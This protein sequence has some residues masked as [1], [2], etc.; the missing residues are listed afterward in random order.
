MFHRDLA[1]PCHTEGRYSMCCMFYRSMFT[2]LDSLQSGNNP[3]KCFTETWLTHAI[4]RGDIAR[5]L[6]PVLLL[7]LHPDTARI[8]IQH[9]NIHQ[10][11]N[12]KL[13]I[14]SS[15]EEMVVT[16][17]RIYAISSEG[18]NVIYHVNPKGA[19]PV[20]RKKTADEQVRSTTLTSLGNKGMQ[21]V[22]SNSRFS[23]NEFSFDKVDVNQVNLRLNP[24]GS[25]SSLD[26][27]LLFDGFDISLSKITNA[28]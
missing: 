7:L 6:E 11:K 24:F 18:G 17:A 27:S 15:D 14:S 5:V 8:S 9:V 12:V 3:A 4:Q 19:K 10:P 22:G 13:S 20:I 16:E 28:K 2:M 21:T 25:N 26:K 1:D 23:E